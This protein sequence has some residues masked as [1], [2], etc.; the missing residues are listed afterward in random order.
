MR[1]YIRKSTHGIKYF[2]EGGG[3]KGFGETMR[4][5]KLQWLCFVSFQWSPKPT[6]F[7]NYRLYLEGR[8]G[9]VAWK[10]KEPHPKR[11]AR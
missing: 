2:I 5:E 9:D 8:T 1:K 4:L 11:G 3:G 6:V 7:N 10:A